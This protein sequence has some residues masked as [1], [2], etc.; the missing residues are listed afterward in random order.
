MWPPQPPGLLAGPCTDGAPAT[1]V[2]PITAT[3]PSYRAKSRT[4]AVP[5]DR[6]VKASFVQNE[7]DTVGAGPPAAPSPGRHVVAPEPGFGRCPSPESAGSAGTRAAAQAM[8]IRNG[9]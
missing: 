6:A 5:S 1:P 2:D 4:V 9:M 3:K 7:E 8:P